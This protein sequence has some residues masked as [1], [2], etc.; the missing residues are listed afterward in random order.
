MGKNT[1]E[2][3]T[4]LF[5]LEFLES[6]EPTGGMV[7]IQSFSMGFGVLTPLRLTEPP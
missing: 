1:V 3:S 7:A 5:E 4:T 2:Q 6:T